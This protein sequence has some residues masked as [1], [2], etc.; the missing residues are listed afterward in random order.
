MPGQRRSWVQSPLSEGNGDCFRVPPSN[1]AETRLTR[2]LGSTASTTSACRRSAF[3]RRPSARDTPTCRP[4]GRKKR[5]CRSV[6]AARRCGRS[7]GTSPHGDRNGQQGVAVIVVEQIRVVDLR[8]AH[9]DH[10]IRP[11]AVVAPRIIEQINVP[12]AE[13]GAAVFGTGAG[14][15]RRAPCRGRRR[16]EI[17][18][19]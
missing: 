5:M 14:R 18:V 6:P 12:E 16:P 17:A 2:C 13:G 19:L 11:P 10:E 8:C 4:R 3:P 9:A 1:L 7:S 15:D